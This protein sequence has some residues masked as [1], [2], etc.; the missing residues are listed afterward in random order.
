[1]DHKTLLAA[2][3]V[4]AFACLAAAVLWPPQCSSGP[5]AS[6]GDSMLLVGCR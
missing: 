5:S 4:L 3:I 1:M 2:L 6:I